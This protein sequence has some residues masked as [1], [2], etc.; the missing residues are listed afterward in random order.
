MLLPGTT[1][2]ATFIVSNIDPSDGREIPAVADWQGPIGAD[3]GCQA[4]IPYRA[5]F[6][7]V[8]VGDRNAVVIAQATHADLLRTAGAY[9]DAEA[10]VY[11][12]RVPAGKIWS[13]LYIDDRWEVGVVAR[14][15]QARS[16]PSAGPAVRAYR[17]PAQCL[18]RRQPAGHGQGGR[19]PRGSL[20]NR[21]A[22]G[23]SNRLGGNPH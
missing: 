14:D 17:T 8:C 2:R 22:R 6:R 20:H 4:G 13:Y 7:T 16:L 23:R 15:R 19:P 1:F 12:L 10:V 21:H 9:T 3:M 18:R 5:C 11:R